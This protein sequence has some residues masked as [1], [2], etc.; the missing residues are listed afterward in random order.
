[1]GPSAQNPFAAGFNHFD[2]IGQFSFD[3]LFQKGI[4]YAQAA[5]SLAARTAANEYV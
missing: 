3:N 4:F 5:G 2:F 1:M